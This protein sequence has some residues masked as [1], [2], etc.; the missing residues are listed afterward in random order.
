MNFFHFSPILFN[1]AHIIFAVHLEK[2]FI[3]AFFKLCIVH[4]LD[5]HTGKSGKTNYRL[6][7]KSGKNV[8]F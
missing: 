8:E 6:G 4:L 7:K 1:V 5:N 3:P 2:S